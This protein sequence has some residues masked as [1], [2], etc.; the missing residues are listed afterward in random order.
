MLHYCPHIITKLV[1]LRFIIAKIRSKQ[2]N[3]N[4][5]NTVLGDSVVE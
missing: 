1:N 2:G 4:K 3:N 5:K